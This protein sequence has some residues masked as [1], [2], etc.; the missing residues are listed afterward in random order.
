M[1]PC[2]KHPLGHL[3]VV[4][5]RASR[6]YRVDARE[7]RGE[8][9]F[10]NGLLRPAEL[11]AD[12]KS[13]R[14]IRRVTFVLAT[15]VDEK[16]VRRLHL[17]IVV[18]VVQHAGVGPGRDDRRISD[19]LRAGTQE[20][21]RKLGLDLIFVPVG[22]RACHRPAMRAARN[23]GRT[24]DMPQFMLVLVQAHRRERRAHIDHGFRHRNAGADAIAQLVERSRDRFVPMRVQAARRIQS[25]AV[26]TKVR[27]LCGKFTHRIRF[28][29]TEDLARCVR[30]VTKA[31]PDLALDVL[32][33]AEQDL[34]GIALVLTGEQQNDRLGFGKS[35]HI[36][37][38]TV[39]PIRKM[40]IR[41]ADRLGRGRNRRDAAASLAAHLG[42]ELRAPRSMM[43]MVVVHRGY[44]KGARM[45]D[46][47][48]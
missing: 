19:R 3:M 4:V 43:L 29:E 27:K 41:V 10:V 48:L 11:A 45:V 9:E 24:A 40:R 30:P 39:W 17:A 46:T 5:K 35:G 28:V 33:P 18:A 25:R 44:R 14:D 31:I 2:A 36:I 32:V 37:E 26:A 13:A 20:F 42:D 15:G 21:V 34:P 16:Q 22:S 6:L 12:W 47:A 23:V 1:S 38:I 7:L 8:H